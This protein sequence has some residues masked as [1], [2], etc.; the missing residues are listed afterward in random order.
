MAAIV[1]RPAR[2]L[3]AQARSTFGAVS[4]S[5]FSPQTTRF[6][7]YLQPPCGTKSAFWESPLRR[8]VFY[9]KLPRACDLAR[10]N[11]TR[12]SGLVAP[13]RRTRIF[14]SLGR[15]CTLETAKER[16]PGRLRGWCDGASIL[17]QESPRSHNE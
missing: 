13:A 15:C 4:A 16:P 7:Y 1:F 3:A 14:R 5:C 17:L 2:Q 9:R 10:Q 6:F 12:A 8:S 11:F